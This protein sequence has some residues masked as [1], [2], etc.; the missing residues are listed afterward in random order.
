MQR[1]EGFR[2]LLLPVFGHVGKPTPGARALTRRRRAGADALLA[3]AKQMRAGEA[4]MIVR[5]SMML[6]ALVS[7]AVA[8]ALER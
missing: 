7:L 2:Q 8:V 1:A 3:W 4:A 5:R 6:A